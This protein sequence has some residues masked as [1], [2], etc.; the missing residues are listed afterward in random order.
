MA[1][2]DH[3]HESALAEAGW[4]PDPDEVHQ[5]RYFDGASWTGHVTHYGP[6]PCSGC[7]LLRPTG[8]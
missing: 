4:Y 2:T 7:F 5:F 1:L 3:H 6:T 8:G